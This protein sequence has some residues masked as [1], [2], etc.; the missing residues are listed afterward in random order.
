MVCVLLNRPEYYVLLCLF[1]IMRVVIWMMHKENSVT[2]HSRK[3]RLGFAFVFKSGLT[4]Q[5]YVS[6]LA[7]FLFSLWLFFFCFHLFLL[8][9]DDRDSSSPDMQ[10]DYIF[11]PQHFFGQWTSFSNML[12]CKGRGSILMFTFLNLCLYI[13]ILIF[14]FIRDMLFLQ[15]KFLIIPTSS[16]LCKYAVDGF[17]GLYL[18]ISYIYDK[19]HLSLWSSLNNQK[20]AWVYTFP[21]KEGGG[22]ALAPKNLVTCW[23]QYYALM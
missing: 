19:Y 17:W 13:Y 18:Y 15:I 23:A 7:Q 20:Y 8:I 16:Q 3:V 2:T 21:D 5:V 9:L 10:G 14:F 22:G 6:S 4:Y 1:S 12:V 11:F